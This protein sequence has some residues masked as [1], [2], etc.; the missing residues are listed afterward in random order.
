[1]EVKIPTL[2]HQ[3]RKKRSNPG[4]NGVEEKQLPPFENHEGSGTSELVMLYS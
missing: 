1:M 4:R 3:R 2:S